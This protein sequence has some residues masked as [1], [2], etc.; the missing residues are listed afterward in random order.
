MILKATF[1]AQRG[2]KEI[3]IQ[4]LG[5]MK[6][7]SA[8]QREA[9]AFYITASWMHSWI[10]FKVDMQ[11]N[12]ILRKS[13]SS[14]SECKR[15]PDCVQPIMTMSGQS[16]SQHTETTC[17]HDQKS[18]VIKLWQ[19]WRK[20]EK[21]QTLGQHPSFYAENEGNLQEAAWVFVCLL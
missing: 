16:T 15:G 14:R 11:E 19:G 2:P 8:K 12:T 6:R 13:N 21:F 3:W 20:R 17:R 10:A 5:P 9:L 7:F 18:T 4:R 1:E